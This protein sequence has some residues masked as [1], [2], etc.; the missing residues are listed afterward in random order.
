MQIIQGRRREAGG[1]LVPSGGEILWYGIASAIPAG[2]SIDVAA[3][4]VFVKAVGGGEASNVIQ[5]ASGHKHIVPATDPVPDHTHSFGGGETG[6]S[7]GTKEFYGTANEYTANAGHKHAI[8]TG[9]SGYGG[10]HQ[11]VTSDTEQVTIYPPYR[12]LY[13]ITATTE[14]FVPVNGVIMW[15]NPIAS[16]PV[17]FGI[18]D[19][20][21]ATPDLRDKFILGAEVD[22]DISSPAGGAETHKHT[23][24][25][26]EQAGNHSHTFSGSTGGNSSTSKN[27]SDY[28][29]TTAAKGDHG[30]GFSGETNAD[31]VH[32][33]TIGE[34]GA[35]SNI[36][37]F[38]KLYFL[39][40]MS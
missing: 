7:S 8:N 6:S 2:W 18:C 21:N 36:P 1:Y 9:V 22:G 30:H 4:D 39:M 19:G 35:A 27:A 12:R 11:H 29:G 15:D 31:L 23:N 26:T 20:A 33:H 14:T 38:I 17:G 16:K 13:W 24:P 28:A 40:R 37:V 25:K 32:D 5:G 34:T 3:K 10:W